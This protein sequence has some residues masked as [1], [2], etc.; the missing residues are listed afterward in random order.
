MVANLNLFFMSNSSL[1]PKEGRIQPK[2][3]LVNLIFSLLEI[4]CIIVYGIFG[5][6]AI[7]DALGSFDFNGMFS[8][9][10]IAIW[11]L[12]GTVFLYSLI[13]LIFKK[14][15]TRYVKG[16]AICNLVWVAFNICGL[17]F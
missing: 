6:N 1:S 11:V 16:V 7:I 9:V 12:S 4:V 2:I 5:F 17:V 3:W 15:R 10:N 8:D 14:L 13:F